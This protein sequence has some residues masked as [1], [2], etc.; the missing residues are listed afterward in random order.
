MRAL[1]AALLLAAFGAG[2]APASSLTALERQRLIAHFQMTEGWLVEEVAGLSPAQIRFRPA[3]GAWSILEVLDHLAVAEPIY[4]QD[5]QDAMKSPPARPGSLSSDESILWYG[6]DRTGR[7]K[8]VPAELP[9][10]EV[11]DP[12]AALDLLRKLHA[13]IIEY[14]RAT[15]DDLRAHVV[16]REGC[17]AYQWMLL[18]STHEQRHLLQ[19]REIKADAKFPNTKP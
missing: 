2:A 11:R 19:I 13:R 3:P 15:P 16:K 9:K 10:G 4:W 12:R 7:R 5:L 1:A 6:I 14:A 8:A 18:I 17:D